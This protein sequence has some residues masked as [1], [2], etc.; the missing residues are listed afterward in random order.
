MEK[1]HFLIHSL[2]EPQKKIL[3]VH[4]KYLGNRKGQ[5]TQSLRLAEMLM[6]SADDVPS[7]EECSRQIYGS[8][9]YGAIQKAKSRLVNKIKSL[10]VF[11]AGMEK[12]GDDEE[13][14]D[15]HG[16]LI[17]WKTTLFHI[18]LAKTGNSPLLLNILDE[19]I[20]LAKEYEVYSSLVEMLNFKKWMIGY[21]NG[22]TVWTEMTEQVDF[23][24]RCNDALMKAVDCYYLGVIRA[25]FTDKANKRSYQYFLRD[26]IA[27][28]NEEYQATQSPIVAYY[29]K[30]LEIMYYES[31]N[32]IE[33]TREVSLEMLRIIK[34]N[35]SVH[36]R[37]RVANIYCKLAS[38]DIR[39]ENYDQAVEN[40][41]EARKYFIK[42]TS[43]FYTAIDFEFLAHFYQHNFD[44][45]KA[46]CLLLLKSTQKEM[47][48]FRYAKYLFYQANVY[49]MQA[50]FKEALAVLNFKLELSKDRQG[51]DLSIRLLK[52]QAL[53]EL[54]RTDEASTHAD[55]LL[56]QAGRAR[57]QENLTARSKLIVRILRMLNH[58]GFSGSRV[59]AKLE[60]YYKMLAFNATYS[61]EPLSSELIPFDRWLATHYRINRKRPPQTLVRQP[62]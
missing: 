34:E 33:T 38:C 20:R 57:V 59:R 51:W 61:W 16:I 30:H 15:R 22:E 37:L 2:S 21:R 4:L 9:N 31:G 60:Q 62:S 54:D 56:K 6:K 19:I 47:G 26:S 14:L 43:N 40:A 23:Y 24:K 28:L 35:K 32:N 11:D 52:I 25:D 36:R 10:L 1:L 45:S 46:L 42:N 49:F 29:A 3:K 18:L 50:K 13:N 39:L 53:I 17:R 12:R 55:S 8:M 41:L 7:I 44:K 27:E 58:E 5:D 48:D